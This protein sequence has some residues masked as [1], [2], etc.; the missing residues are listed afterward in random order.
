MLLQHP[1]LVCL[2]A[3][4]AEEGSW[5]FTMALVIGEDF[6]QWVRGPEY[7]G[8]TAD[9]VPDEPFE[10][11]QTGGVPSTR[12]HWDEARLRQGLSDLVRGLTALH[13]ADLLHR[14]VKPNN[15]LVQ[16]DGRVVLVDFGIAA[17]L[18]TLDETESASLMGTPAYMAP[19]QATANPLSPASDLYSLGVMLFEAVTG[20]L[21]FEGKAVSMLMAK[22]ANDGPSPKTLDAS[23]PEDLCALC[24]D[25]MRRDPARRPA[26]QEILSRLGGQSVMVRETASTHSAQSVFVGRQAALSALNEQW[27]RASGGQLSIVAVRGAAGVGKTALVRRF[28]EQVDAAED[29]AVLEGRCYERESARAVVDDVMARWSRKAFHV[30]HWFAMRARA[31]ISLYE[32]NGRQAWAEVQKGWKPLWDSMLLRLQATRI[33][34]LHLHASCALAAAA[35]GQDT[36][37]NRRIA[38][39]DVRRLRSEKQ[40]WATGLADLLTVA[41]ALRWGS[42]DQAVDRL[43][44]AASALDEADMALLANVA[45]DRLAR[46]LGGDEGKALVTRVEDWMRDQG[47]IKPAHFGRTVVPDIE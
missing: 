14:D 32:G 44:R 34:A 7:Q 11:F 33:V 2:H 31:L 47:V 41:D 36:A 5:Y 15:V 20:C 16:P 26:A 3:L 8:P 13:A 27:E 35:E 18:K 45:R 9:T 28:L 24:T 43:R 39:H 30:Q 23:L 1:N 38:A 42:P 10:V 29:V 17:D 37:E 19:E 6:L 22:A 46:V 21:P 40:A 25:L 12:R 4:F